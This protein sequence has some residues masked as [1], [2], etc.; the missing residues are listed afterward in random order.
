MVSY[1]ESTSVQ[2]PGSVDSIDRPTTKSKMN[3]H[4]N[5][6][7]LD[8]HIETANFLSETGSIGSTDIRS[9]RTQTQPP[10]LQHKKSSKMEERKSPTNKLIKPPKLPPI[11]D[12]ESN[13]MLLKEKSDKN[14]VVKKN[15]ISQETRNWI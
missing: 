9:P 13:F 15:K 8:K 5:M 11:Q 6:V 12:F 10:K 1:D 4:S 3:K 2:A 7:F 14:P